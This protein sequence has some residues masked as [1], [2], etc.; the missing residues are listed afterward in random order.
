MAQP[1]REELFYGFP[2]SFIRALQ[3][4]IHFLH[5]FILN[6]SIPPGEPREHRLGGSTWNVETKFNI[7]L[8]LYIIII[9]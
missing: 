3:M 7:T 6:I 4:D 5:V 8:I 2:K 9:E 1:L